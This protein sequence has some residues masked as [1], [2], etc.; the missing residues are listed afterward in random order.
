MLSMH[1]L[2]TVVT[3]FVA[4]EII[5]RLSKDIYKTREMQK[6]REGLLKLNWTSLNIVNRIENRSCLKKY[7]QIKYYLDSNSSIISKWIYLRHKS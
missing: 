4:S 1:Y 2:Q 7:I 6:T 5:I 3:I